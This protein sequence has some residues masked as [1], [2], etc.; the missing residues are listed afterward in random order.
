MVD[1]GRERDKDN[2]GDK[3]RGEVLEALLLGVA[4]DN[5]C[6]SS[7]RVAAAGVVVGV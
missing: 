5:A 1:G 3:E 6:S 4:E 7:A 2:K